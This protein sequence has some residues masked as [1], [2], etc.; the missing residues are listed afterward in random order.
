[1]LVILFLCNIFYYTSYGRKYMDNFL[2]ILCE[3][4]KIF[5]NIYLLHYNTELRPSLLS[6]C[7][8]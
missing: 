7:F 6:E 4:F 2:I 5:D 1:M 3:Q 8:A